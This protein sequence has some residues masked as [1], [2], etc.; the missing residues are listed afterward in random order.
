MSLKVSKKVLNKLEKIYPTTNHDSL[1]EYRNELFAIDI[2]EG[3]EL[4]DGVL[5]SFTG[6]AKTGDYPK[7]N[8]VR[9]YAKVVGIEDSRA[10]R[11]NWGVGYEEFCSWWKR[12]LCEILWPL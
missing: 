6:F 11:R 2:P 10:P 1:G 7:T 5:R 3:G 12:K 9:F 8:G 4:S